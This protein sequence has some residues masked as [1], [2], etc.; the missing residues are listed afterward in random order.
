MAAKQ[1]PIETLSASDLEISVA[2]EQSIVAVEP[3]QSRA[4][5]E[6]VEDDGTGHIKIIAKLEEMKVL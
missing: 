6:V 3:V 4:A 1:K 5:G 2:V